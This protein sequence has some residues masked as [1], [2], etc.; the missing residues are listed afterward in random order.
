MSKRDD[1]NVA[2]ADDVNSGGKSGI[3]SMGGKAGYGLRSNC[4]AG[5]SESEE[6]GPGLVMVLQSAISP[7]RHYFTRT[8]SGVRGCGAPGSVKENTSSSSCISVGSRV[9]MEY[10]ATTKRLEC[11]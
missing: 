3:G 5:D 4:F 1:T 7:L 2:G 6:E 10:Q 8:C 11:T 9:R